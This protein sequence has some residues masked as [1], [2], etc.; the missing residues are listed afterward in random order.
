MSRGIKLRVIVTGGCGFIGSHIVD[1][2]INDG[3][4]VFVVD[5]LSTGNIRYLNDRAAFY[6]VDITDKKISRVFDEV[7]PEVVYHSAAQIDV[8][9]SIKEPYFDAETNIIG[10]VNILECCR[11]YG[12]RKIIYAS[13]AAV[14]GNPV[15]LP[16]D[17]EHPILPISFYGVSKHAPEHYIKVYSSLYGF[18]YTILRYSNVYGLRQDPKG[19]GGVISIFIDKIKNGEAPV[20]FG[21]GEQTRD[22]V[23]VKD[24]AQANIKALESGDGQVLNISTNKEVSVN[25]LYEIIKGFSGTI[26]AAIHRDERKGDIRRSYLEN[27]KALKYLGWMPKYS[28]EQGLKETMDYYLR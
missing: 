15:Y 4:Q 24:I 8:Q 3:N 7:K 10:T 11:N 22:F 5:N 21:D 18:R 23:Y 12:V 2:L 9:R 26:L 16:L 20:I 25:R 1:Y 14:Y 17:E 13:S 27:K 6:N 19:E 28:I